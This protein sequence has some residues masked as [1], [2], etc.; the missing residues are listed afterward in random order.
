MSV[1]TP[2]TSVVICAYSD[3]RW[4][5]LRAAVSSVL[6]QARA[7]E[8]VIVVID[9]NPGL[10]ERARG[11]D[12]VVSVS[13]SRCRGLSGARN[14]GVEMA[15]GAVVAFIDDDAVA[16]PN[17][18][19]NLLLHYRRPDV[20]GVG[21]AV[22]PMWLA[23]RP[24]AFPEE[25]D[26]VVGCSYRGLSETTTTVRNFIGAN[27]SF[28]RDLLIGLGGFRSGLG[29]VG[30]VPRGCEETELCIRAARRWPAKVLVHE[31]SA[32]VR[33]RVPAQR[34]SVRYFTARCYAEGRSKATVARLAGVQRGLA[35]ELAYTTATLPRG[36]GR[37]LA[38]ALRGDP[39][40]VGRAAAIA[41]GLATTTA[42]YVAG[43]ASVGRKAR[44]EELEARRADPASDEDGR[45]PLR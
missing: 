36:I 19:E 20:M 35:S 1:A 43:A 13:N 27:M 4:D 8:E 26:W 12:G 32:R 24:C 39:G 15:T 3:E 5:D 42:G 38:D 29:R 10:L 40:G 2:T 6:D 17:W 14:T 31:P 34:G 23:G 37:G 45:N 41:V 28:R 11:I 9:H 44:Q 16:S 25:F 33:H 22:E 30:A 21:G 7:P 18:L